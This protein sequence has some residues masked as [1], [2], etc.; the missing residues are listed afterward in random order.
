MGLFID[1]FTIFPQ[2]F[3]W[4]GRPRSGCMIRSPKS[5]HAHILDTTIICITSIESSNDNMH[6]HYMNMTYYSDCVFESWLDPLATNTSVGNNYCWVLFQPVDT[7]P[8][9]ISTRLNLKIKQGHM[10]DTYDG[11]PSSRHPSLNNHD[12]YKFIHMKVCTC[13]CISHK[14]I[15]LNSCIFCEPWSVHE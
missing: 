1:A 5:M 11:I 4:L 2:S 14:I 12:M 15:I 3:V 10:E 6:E 9:L 7:H 13:Y 8:G